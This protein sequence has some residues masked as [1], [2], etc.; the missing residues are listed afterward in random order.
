MR[1]PSLLEDGVPPRVTQLE[2][3][4][5]GAALSFPSWRG[6]PCLGGSPELAWPK[7]KSSQLAPGLN[8]PCVLSQEPL[9]GP[10]SLG[11]R[12]PVGPALVEIL[13]VWTISGSHNSTHSQWPL[14]GAWQGGPLPVLCHLPNCCPDLEHYLKSC[15]RAPPALLQLEGAIQTM[16]G[17]C[18][19]AS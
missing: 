6:W 17:W 4:G 11:C 14:T 13:V 19:P 5:H 10:L 9:P 3:S 7:A 8:L 16:V 18:C 15:R 2:G 12:D 1:G